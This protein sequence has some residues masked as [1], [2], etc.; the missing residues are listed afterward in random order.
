M[1]KLN[2]LIF[3]N[4][5][6]ELL[7]KIASFSSRMIYEL[8]LLN[9]SLRK[10]ILGNLISE[11]SIKLMLD[12]EHINN[13]VEQKRKLND[14]I[15]SINSFSRGISSVKISEKIFSAYFA[16]KIKLQKFDFSNVEYVQLTGYAITESLLNEFFYVFPKTKRLTILSFYLC[17][18]SLKPI[19]DLRINLHAI[20]L[21]FF[22][23]TN[24]H[25]LK[26]LDGIKKVNICSCKKKINYA[27][28]KNVDT[29]Q[30]TPNVI[31]YPQHESVKELIIDADPDI[32][33]LLQLSYVKLIRVHLNWYT[34]NA[35]VQNIYSMCDNE[36]EFTIHKYPFGFV[37]EQGPL[38][39][40]KSVC[41]NNADRFMINNFHIMINATKIRII[42]KKNTV[43][44]NEL[45][46][47]P[48]ITHLIIENMK[49][50]CVTIDDL[51]KFKKLKIFEYFGKLSDSA[52][53]YML[54]KNIT[55]KKIEKEF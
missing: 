10:S 42:G 37:H 41:F 45:S 6:I 48:N 30:I 16:D 22:R 52:I 44:L 50:S 15:L 39:L 14:F 17:E 27:Y 46:N 12:P 53:E 5:P 32:K 1:T 18:N 36:V 11:K 20:K 3:C 31:S 19:Y 47:I 43:T 40:L 24:H 49:K 9:K 4:L 13:T 23:I 26:Y 29:L 25:Q 34:D 55:Y 7:K 38:K 51:S 21:K 8:M 35:M 54:S 28:I 2:S 33:T